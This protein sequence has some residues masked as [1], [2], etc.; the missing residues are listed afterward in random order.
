MITLTE[1]SASPKSQS[2]ALKSASSIKISKSSSEAD[3]YINSLIP[4]KNYPSAQ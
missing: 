2:F 3:N 1:T 4:R